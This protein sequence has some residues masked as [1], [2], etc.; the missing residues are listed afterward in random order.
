MFNTGLKRFENKDIDTFTTDIGMKIR[1]VIYIPL[2]RLL[3][4]FIKR[5][6]IIEQYPQLDKG[7]VYIFAVSHST[8]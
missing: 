2:K 7:K 5:K 8:I 6:V 4:R 1:K 3:K